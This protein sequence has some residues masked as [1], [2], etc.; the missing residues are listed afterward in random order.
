MKQVYKDY[1]ISILLG[2][3]NDTGKITHRCHQCGTDLRPVKPTV[4]KAY[5]DECDEEVK[6]KPLFQY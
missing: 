3:Y 4:K 6:V 1:G 2:E 5:C